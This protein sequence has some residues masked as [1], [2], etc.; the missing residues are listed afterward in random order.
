M[1]ILLDLM[2]HF[3][4]LL[5]NNNK[6]QW[7]KTWGGFLTMYI[8]TWQERDR[9]FME[10]VFF[11]QDSMYAPIP[12]QITIWNPNHCRKNHTK[13]VPVVFCGSKNRG[14]IVLPHHSEI[15]LARYSWLVRWWCRVLDLISIWD[16]MKLL[17]AGLPKI[18]LTIT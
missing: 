15:C 1:I 16:V 11:K 7:Y 4:E 8:V 17:K 13:P 14:F 12:T 5:S 3:Q 9:F 6:K 10:T 18:H 2:V